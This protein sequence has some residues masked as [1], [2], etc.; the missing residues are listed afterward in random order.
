[1]VQYNIACLFSNFFIRSELSYPADLKIK[2]ATVGQLMRRMH[3]MDKSQEKKH[4]PHVNQSYIPTT[5]INADAEKGQASYLIFQ[6]S[7]LQ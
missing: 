4:Q 6:Y 3:N 7:S 2:E 1:M 5:D